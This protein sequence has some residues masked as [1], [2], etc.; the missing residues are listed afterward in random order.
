[1]P[2]TF[3]SSEVILIGLISGIVGG[4]LVAAVC[5]I[6]YQEQS[7]AVVK[8]IDTRPTIVAETPSGEVMVEEEP[9]TNIAGSLILIGFLIVLVIGIAA[10]TI[11][12]SKRSP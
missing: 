2:R 12:L 10:L 4:G 1:M 7:T 11:R 6:I 9:K 3:S 5:S 8:I